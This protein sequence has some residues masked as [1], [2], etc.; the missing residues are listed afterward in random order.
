MPDHDANACY[1]DANISFIKLK[2]DYGNAHQFP[3]AVIVYSIAVALFPTI[4]SITGNRFSATSWYSIKLNQRILQIF[5]TLIA[6]LPAFLDFLKYRNPCKLINPIKRKA[7]RYVP[8]SGTGAGTISPEDSC[9]A[10]RIP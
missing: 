4:F 10:P 5:L 8:G 9:T 1:E 6:C 7:A 2:D 3:Q